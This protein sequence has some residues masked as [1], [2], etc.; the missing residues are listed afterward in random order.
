MDNRND[1]L[2]KGRARPAKGGDFKSTKLTNEAVLDI[3]T[4]PL[5][6]NKLAKKYNVARQTIYDILNGKTWTHIPPPF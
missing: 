5:N 3:K 6:G 2:T 1:M 4:S